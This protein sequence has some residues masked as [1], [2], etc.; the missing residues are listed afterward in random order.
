MYWSRCAGVEHSDKTNGTPQ[1]FKVQFARIRDIRPFPSVN[2][3]TSMNPMQAAAALPCS[4]MSDL[5]IKI[6]NALK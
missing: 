1:R 3:C 2:G 4:S 6:S 5:A